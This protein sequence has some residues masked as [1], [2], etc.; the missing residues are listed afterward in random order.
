[1]FWARKSWAVAHNGSAMRNIVRI[2]QEQFGVTNSAVFEP[3]GPHSLND[4][5][6]ML[7]AYVV[8]DHSLEQGINADNVQFETIR[9]TRSVVSN[10]DRTTSRELELHCLVGY[11]RG[12]RQIITGTMLY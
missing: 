8:L 5:F 2:Y 12:E 3:Q 9:K 6:G 10:Y 1:V 11:K 4:S 7:K